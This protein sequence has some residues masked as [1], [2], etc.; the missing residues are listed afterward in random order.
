MINYANSMRAEIIWLTNDAY[1]QVSVL[2]HEGRIIAD[3]S[4]G[5]PDGLDLLRF[6]DHT[7]AEGRLFPA[8]APAPLRRAAR[9]DEGASLPEGANVRR[10]GV[11]ESA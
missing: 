7:V 5:P 1:R 6:V 11:C 8:P 3:G 10:L 4:E 2:V 9:A